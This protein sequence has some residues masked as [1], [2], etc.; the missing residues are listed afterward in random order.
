MTEEV[1]EI[2]QQTSFNGTTLLDS[3]KSFN[4]QTG[5]ENQTV[6]TTAAFDTISL[7][8]ANMAALTATDTVDSTNYSTYADELS[9][10]IDGVSAGL[11]NLGSLANRMTAK[12]R[13]TSVMQTNTE[14]AYNRIFN[15]DMAS[16]QIEMTKYQILAQA[17]MAMLTQANQNPSSVLTLFR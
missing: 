1:D 2:A 12:E 9:A 11:V 17:S 10:A 5:A 16:E 4:F 7:G 6:W 3:A 13:M 8:M 14:A 15:A